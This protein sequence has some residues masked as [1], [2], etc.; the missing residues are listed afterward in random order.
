MNYWYTLFAIIL[1]VVAIFTQEVIT[2]IM[3]GF[4]LIA[5]VN[6]N[7][8]LKKVLEKFDYKDS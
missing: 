3:L 1:G 8:T 4:I 7:N 5:L 2:F 6:I